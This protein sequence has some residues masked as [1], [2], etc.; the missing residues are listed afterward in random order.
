MPMITGD[1]TLWRFLKD[2]PP[3]DFEMTLGFDTGRLQ[4]GFVVLVLSPLENINFDEIEL[5]GS[6]RWSNNK[7][8][9]N[10]LPM[11]QVIRNRGVDPAALR[12]RFCSFINRGGDNAPAKIL[13]TRKHELGMAYPHANALGL[14]IRS[15]VPAF[16]LKV[17]KAFEVAKT[18]GADYGG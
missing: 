4:S 5:E 17:A 18:F 15:G 11:E 1:C 14:G 16:K 12:K 2:L 8:G 9:K 13:P 10:A 3:R 6:T 7:I